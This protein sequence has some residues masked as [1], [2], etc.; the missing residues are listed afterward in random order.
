PLNA[1]VIVW[2]LGRGWT[3]GCVWIGQKLKGANGGFQSMSTAIGVRVF[4]FFFF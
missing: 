1:W 4:S 3:L 2:N